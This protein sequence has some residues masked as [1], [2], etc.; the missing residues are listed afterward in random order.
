MVVYGRCCNRAPLAATKGRFVA[1]PRAEDSLA[2]RVACISSGP[3]QRS[4]SFDLAC[5][6]LVRRP[7]L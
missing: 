2:M 6:L 1:T 3:L 5:D 7:N 4:A